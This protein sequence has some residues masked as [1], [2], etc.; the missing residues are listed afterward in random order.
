M[1]SSPT[2]APGQANFA[3]DQEGDLGRASK[4][5]QEVSPPGS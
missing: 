3:L 1:T 5:R 4:P 2:E